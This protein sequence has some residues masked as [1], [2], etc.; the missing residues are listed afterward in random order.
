MKK[1]FWDEIGIE[2]LGLGV[3]ILSGLYCFIRSIQKVTLD[4]CQ[5]IFLGDKVLLLI[6]IDSWISP[7]IKVTINFKITFHQKKRKCYVHNTFT[8][9][10]K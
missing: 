7:A 8:I 5:S 6:Y 9:N 4:K 1:T 2:F 10:F 3:L